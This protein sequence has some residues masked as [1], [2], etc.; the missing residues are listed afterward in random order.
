[1]L[2]V[3]LLPHHKANGSTP[4]SSSGI[5]NYNRTGQNNTPT[6]SS[7]VYTSTTSTVTTS[8]QKGQGGTTQITTIASTTTSI[9]PSA[10][11][12]IS[13]YIQ[14]Q[15][16]P[17]GTTTTTIQYAYCVGSSWPSFNQSYY[18][19]L[20]GNGFGPG[21]WKPTTNYS[22]SMI[23]GSCASNGAM[24]YCIGGALPGYGTDAYYASVSSSGIGQ[25][26]KTSDYPVQFID[27]SCT[28]G[29]NYIYCVGTENASYGNESYYA[30]ISS[31][32][33]G[34]WSK[35]TSYPLQ[36]YGGICN[37]YG[38]Y[39]YCVGNNYY[40][41]S[42]GQAVGANTITNLTQIFASQPSYYAAIG[43]AGIGRWLPTNATPVPVNMGSCP[44]YN[45]TIYCVGGSY[46]QESAFE[47]LGNVIASIISGNNAYSSQNSVYNL[48][49]QSLSNTLYSNLTS[50]FAARVSASGIGAWNSTHPYPG[51]F[52]GG[53][54]FASSGSL[55]CI[56][57][58][59]PSLQQSVNY[60]NLSSNTIG[61]WTLARQYP[62]PFSGGSCA[63]GG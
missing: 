20:Y 11:L 1:M 16:N 2:L 50:T 13:A 55:Y 5:G 61:A 49:N 37:A 9:S 43:G 47:A 60:A 36:F 38:N 41:S 33:I 6:S 42:S 12:N 27:G 29:G 46:S 8:V 32:G 15:R 59:D 22:I 7:S 39:I 25:W 31:S 51:N 57:S 34:Q 4:N 54:C 58:T 56:G 21:A 62:I 30:P 44:I 45:G 3:L 48:L 52:T 18:A 17:L 14:S 63:V 28:I 35:T 40:N 10:P 23:G 53:A 24:I 26:S 19:P